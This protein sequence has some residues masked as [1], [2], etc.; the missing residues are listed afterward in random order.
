VFQEL[1]DE[2]P[3]DGSSGELLTSSNVTAIAPGI[4]PSEMPST[5]SRFENRITISNSE[6]LS[7]WKKAG[8]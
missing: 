6:L 5:A 3:S 7:S 4:T 2:D 1:K 8:V